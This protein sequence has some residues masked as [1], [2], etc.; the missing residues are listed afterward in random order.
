MKD[1]NEDCKW[2]VNINRDRGYVRCEKEEFVVGY[3]G[4]LICPTYC[5]CRE[6]KGYNKE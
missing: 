1:I 4:Y 5:K 2:F 6:H 3:S